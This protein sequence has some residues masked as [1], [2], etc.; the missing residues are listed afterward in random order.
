MMTLV[1]T[2]LMAVLSTGQGG[3]PNAAATGTLTVR[4]TGFAHARGSAML[5]LTDSTGFLGAGR[6]LR[7]LAVT[8]RDGQATAVFA[9][10]AHGRYAIQAYH[11]E[12]GNRRLDRN[13]FGIPSEPYG[14]SND[15]RNAMRAPT[16]EEAAFT[17]ASTA[18]TIDIRVR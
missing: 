10:V 1:A 7:T 13:F 11:D 17:L 4:L 2:A 12:N 3:Q 14:F 5:A 18:M 9:G 15:A 8:I 6:A 16:Y